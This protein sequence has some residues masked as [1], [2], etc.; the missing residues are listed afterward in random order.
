MQR[1]QKDRDT[2]SRQ[3][4]DTLVIGAGIIGIAVAHY[5]KILAPTHRV[6]LAEP[7][8]PMALTSAQSGE[9]Y[10]NWWPHPHMTA[11]TDHSIGLMEQ[12]ARET[13]N[14]IAMTRR[15]YVLAS[16]LG[17]VDAMLAELAAGYRDA[18]GGEI[19]L[20]D[21]VS[22]ATYRPP[23]SADWIT[24]PG[25]VDV[26]TDAALIRR[27]FPSFDPDVRSAVHIRGAGSISG[28]QLGQYMLES[29]RNSG[30]ERI[31]GRVTGLRQNGH[32]IA[33]LGP[34]DQVIE[35]GQIVNAAGPFVNE[36]AELLGTGLPVRNVL[37]Q[38][39]A[40][41]DRAQAIPRNMP[42]SIDLDR[43][44]IDWSPEEREL[45]AGDP[46]TA[47][48]CAEMPGSI[49][50]RPD[51][52]DHGRWIKLGWA[53]NDACSPPAAD[54]T[55]SPHF[56]E[57]VLR[58][59]ARLHPALKA[60]FGHL[61][62]NTRHYGGFYTMTDE[63][64]PLIGPMPGGETLL[65]GAFVA[66]AMSG[67]GTMAACAAGDLCARWVLGK[68]LPDYASALSVA[69]YRDA[70]LMAALAAQTSRGVL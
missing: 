14:R 43:Q 4:C 8:N 69:R 60:Y 10:R 40:F 53:F 48:L 39:I 33:Q 35:A 32:Y 51:G 26:L 17:S 30:G 5:L 52:G 27:T 65:P 22:A 6:I 25:G 16:R 46:S 21:S 42:F 70:P 18:A 36:V 67:F 58:G 24:A 68:R 56:P 28:Q 61:P 12:I 44:F 19:R 38:K 62:R 55:L 20:H 64:W 15:G 3:T 45:L 57:I 37:Q 59:A 7:G 11:F 50:C 9:N 41:E 23:E 31:T 1:F 54:P 63:N 49:H 13:D 29:F 66:G 34:N 47:W 2:V